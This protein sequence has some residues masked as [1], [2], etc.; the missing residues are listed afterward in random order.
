MWDKDFEKRFNERFYSI[1]VGVFLVVLG[2][3]I[4]MMGDH[5][6][7]LALNAFKSAYDYNL[8]VYGMCDMNAMGHCISY[9]DLY[10]TGQ[11][12][13]MLG[14]MLAMVGCFYFGMAWVDAYNMAEMKIRY[15]KR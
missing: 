9:T 6:I 4:Y 14:I 15:R 8:P 3:F 2:V 13:E 5:N 11:I 1:A 7:D 12:E 10:M